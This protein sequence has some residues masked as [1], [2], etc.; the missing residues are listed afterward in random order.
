MKILSGSIVFLLVLFPHFNAFPLSDPAL[1]EWREFSETTDAKRLNEWLRCRARAML[2][3]S[4]CSDQLRVGTP[5]FYG[6]LGIFVTLKKGKN[7]RGCYGAFFHSMTDIAEVLSDYLSGAFTRD[8]RYK[9]ISLS[10]LEYTEI[11][12]T[13]ASQPHVVNEPD[14]IDILRY[15]IALSCGDAAM[16][17]YVPYELRGVQDLRKYFREKECQIS[18]FEAVTIR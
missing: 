9:P 4:N 1:E 15:G 8:P 5:Q 12:I 7:V 11:I 16:T 17:I 13:I 14:S 10:E 2:S 18:A 6:K 3:G